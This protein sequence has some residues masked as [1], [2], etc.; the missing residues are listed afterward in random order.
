M[1]TSSHQLNEVAQE[2]KLMTEVAQEEKLMTIESADCRA[3]G[4]GARIGIRAATEPL[5]VN[6]ST[7]SL[8]G[9]AVPLAKVMRPE[10]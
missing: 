5:R 10:S 3:A 2:E 8:S 6:V 7:A 4:P 1:A 9:P